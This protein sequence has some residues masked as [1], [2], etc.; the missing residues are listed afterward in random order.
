[1]NPSDQTPPASETV[2]SLVTFRITTPGGAPRWKSIGSMEWQNV[3]RFA[4]LTG[5]NGA[6]KTQLLEL[7][8]YKLSGMPHPSGID[9]SQI[10]V[11]VDGETYST[12]DVVYLPSRWEMTPAIQL[13]FAQIQAA[14]EQLWNELQPQNIQHDFRRRNLKVRIERK[15]GIT[16]IHALNQAE[17]KRLLPD[18]FTFLLEESEVVSGLAH[19][20]VAYRFRA[21]EL[22]EAGSNQGQIVAALGAAPWEALNDVFRVAEFPFSVVSPTERGLLEM[23]EFE[24]QHRTTGQRIKPNDLSSGEKML[25]G[26]VFWLYSSQHRGRFPKLFLLDEPDAHLHPSMTRHFIDVVN[27]VLVNRFGVRVILSTHS[28]STVALSP[29]TSLFEMSPTAPRIRQAPSAARA[30]GLLTSGLVTVSASSRFVLVEDETDVEFYN[31]VRDV[32]M[33]Y[34]QSKDKCAIAPAP[35]LIFLPASR[36]KGANKTG[37]GSTVVTQWVEKFDMPPLSELVRGI[38]DRDADTTPS[39]GRVR[40]LGRYSIENYELDPL[41]VY[42]LLVEEGLAAA[43][44]HVRLTPG[45]QHQL[46]SMSDLQLQSLVDYIAAAVQP[47]LADLNNDDLSTKSVELT[48]GVLLRYPAWMLDRRGHDLL[49]AFQATFGGARLINQVRLRRSLQACRM[50]AKELAVLLAALQLDLQLG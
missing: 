16:N 7:L 45:D 33:D 46:R 42:A 25:M 49:P 32:L 24:L 38:I 9:L 39:S 23:Y 19:V 18:D 10:Q 15:L 27:E 43:T 48:N 3:P 5:P 44:A 4:V 13:G 40:K 17:F 29:E 35:S 21:A 50:I 28:P 12:G 26:L 2:S 37:G 22:R 36:G 1:M 30:I 41:V 14:K 20:F 6:G 11:D 8:A 34:S 47:N 31:V